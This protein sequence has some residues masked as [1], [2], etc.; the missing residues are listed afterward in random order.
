M[1]AG[2]KRMATHTNALIFGAKSCASDAVVGIVGVGGAEREDKF[3]N[4]FGLQPEGQ[5][6]GHGPGGCSE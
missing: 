3:K 1:S 4:K 2:K 5:A 6:A